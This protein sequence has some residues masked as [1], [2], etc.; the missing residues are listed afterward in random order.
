MGLG[1]GSFGRS[2]GQEGSA[3]P[4]GLPGLL[5]T[6]D[7][8]RILGKDPRPRPCRPDPGSQPPELTHRRLVRKLPSVGHCVT[9]AWAQYL[10][11]ALKFQIFLP[12][13]GKLLEM[14]RVYQGVAP[15]VLHSHHTWVSRAAFQNFLQ[16]MGTSCHT[17][18]GEHMMTVSPNLQV[19]I[20]VT[21]SSAEAKVQQKLWAPIFPLVPLV[22]A[23][24]GSWNGLSLN[25]YKKWQRKWGC[26]CNI[27][28]T[29]SMKTLGYIREYRYVKI[30]VTLF[31]FDFSQKRKF[32]IV[33]VFLQ[34]IIEI[35]VAW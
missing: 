7:T 23:F 25:A 8:T 1:G 30:N 28:F 9:A 16:P 15:A 31:D 13:G 29:L 32:C 22:T 3:F 26:A 5:F 34:W 12:V 4:G 24:T 27:Q 20:F 18:L 35:V 14:A 10:V 6:Q 11:S 17:T 33:Q 19:Y 21:G 2:S